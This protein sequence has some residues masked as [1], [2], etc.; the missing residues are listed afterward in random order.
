MH[1]RWRKFCIIKS[2]SKS[3]APFPCI[4]ILE[5]SNYRSKW[6]LVGIIAG[7]L[8]KTEAEANLL[9]LYEA[10][11]RTVGVKG[12]KWVREKRKMNT[13][14]YIS[15]NA[16]LTTQ[17]SWT[18]SKKLKFLSLCEFPL[19]VS[20]SEFLTILILSYSQVSLPRPNWWTLDCLSL[21]FCFLTDYLTAAL[22]IE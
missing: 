7:V 6:S 18:S 14:W 17:S 8:K 11:D 9:M 10:S 2:L 4:H 21:H 3:E 1:L 19:A 15:Q 20:V 22:S 16:Q 13:R 5:K 12:K